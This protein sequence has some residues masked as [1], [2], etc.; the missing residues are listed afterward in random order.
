MNVVTDGEKS[1]TATV[2]SG[3]P[4]GTVLGPL[5]FLCHINDLLEAVKSNVRLFADDCIL[6]RK[7]RSVQDTCRLQQ[8]LDSLEKWATIWGMKFNPESVPYSE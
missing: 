6:Y 1:P 7:I 2:S 4:R 3:V 5:L 8:D